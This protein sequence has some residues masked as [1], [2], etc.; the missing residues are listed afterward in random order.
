MNGASAACVRQIHATHDNRL[1]HAQL[2][3]HGVHCLA[4]HRQVLLDNPPDN[5]QVNTEVVVDDH[6]AETGN[7]APVNFRVTL[8]TGIRQTRG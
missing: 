8:L 6:V 2:G 3:E 1:R 5:I 4:E 7:L